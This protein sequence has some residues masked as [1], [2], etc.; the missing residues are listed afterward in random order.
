MKHA[1][2]LRAVRTA[3][4]KKKNKQT[5]KQTNNDYQRHSTNIHQIH[6]IPAVCGRNT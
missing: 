6:N 3:I 5:N 4:L 1:Y 2:G